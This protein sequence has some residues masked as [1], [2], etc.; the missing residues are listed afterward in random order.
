[1]S[2]CA[3]QATP[4]P[5]KH[6]LSISQSP[7]TEEDHHKYISFAGGLRYL[8]IVGSLLYATQTRPDIQFS[9]S[10]ISQFGGN[11]G[12][13]HLQ[14]SKHIL[15]YLKGTAHFVLKMGRTGRH[16]IDL[17]GWTDSDWAQDPDSR[18]SIGGFLPDVAGGVV[19]WQSKKQPTVALSTV[20]AEYMAAA[21]ATN[22]SY[23]INEV[24]TVRTCCNDCV[25][26]EFNSCLQHRTLLCGF[27]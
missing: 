27:I 10:L 13:P 22:T 9:V 3:A 5:V 16:G 14:A 8:E 2:K 26:S 21:N 23:E 15:R 25:S 11:P 24:A 18:C 19:S 4:L 1:M 6:G 17:V 7:I 12:I 20:E